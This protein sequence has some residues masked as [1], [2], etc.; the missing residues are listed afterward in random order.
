[1]G[2]AVCSLL[3]A[4]LLL[5]SLPNQA[6]KHAWCM[7][8]SGLHFVAATGNAACAKLFCKAGADLNLCDKDGA[9]SSD[10]SVPACP[11]RAC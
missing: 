7:R 5:Q 11:Q 8:R 10:P 1:V 4:F 9:C 6:L 3:L 2:P